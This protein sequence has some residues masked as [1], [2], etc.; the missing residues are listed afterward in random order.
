MAPSNTRSSLARAP[1]WLA[2]AFAGPGGGAALDHDD[3]DPLG[4]APQALGEGP[5]VPPLSTYA[6]ATLV[7]GSSAKYSR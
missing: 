6:S 3:R 2:A 5:A 1:V 7:S 4:H